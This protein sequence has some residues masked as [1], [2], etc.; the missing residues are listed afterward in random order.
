[1]KKM[2]IKKLRAVV[3]VSVLLV[4]CLSLSCCMPRPSDDEIKGDIPDDNFVPST[5]DDLDAAIADY[6]I[7]KGRAETVFSEI[8]D[9]PAEAF[10]YTEI[11]DGVRIDR[12][13]GRSDIVVIP[14]YIDGRAVT[15]LGSEAFCRVNIRSLYIPDSIT[16]IDMGAIK[17]C[18]SLQL[19]R[20]PFVGDGDSIS[21]IG[22]IFGA[23]SHDTNAIKIPVSLETVVIGEGEDSICERAFYRAKSIRA[24][25]LEGAT[26]IGEFAFFEC[27]ALCYVELADNTESIGAY[28][29][30]GCGALAKIEMPDT[31]KSIGLGAFYLCKSMAQMTLY[32]VGDGGE[33]THLGYIFGAES[34][35]WNENFV[36]SSLC[37]IILKDCKRIENRAFANCKNIVSIELPDT[38]EHIG[39]RAFVNCRSLE[40]LRTP[41]SLKMISDDAFFGCDNMISLTVTGLTTISSQAFYGCDKLEDISISDS[42]TIHEN[43]FEKQIQETETNTET[44]TEEET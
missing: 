38:L 21:H 30:S 27:D 40:A 18:T 13:I 25:V 44:N 39:I 11:T 41:E 19:L 17:D 4:V 24:V 34:A 36:P 37:S 6:N 29:F 12:Y 43:A 35:D 14:Q 15:E 10:E 42:A 33:H 23:D 2:I 22:H 5:L 1:M 7:Y 9:T 20:L 16:H 32:F 3:C 28:A 26:D 8:T 31:V